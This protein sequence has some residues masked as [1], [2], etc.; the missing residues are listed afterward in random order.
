LCSNVSD[1]FTVVNIGL[2]EELLNGFE[3]YPNPAQTQVNIALP[4]SAQIRILDASGREVHNQWVEQRT[5]IDVQ[6]WARGVYMVQLIKS[7]GIQTL[8]VMLN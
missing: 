3:I 6:Q 4:G 8:P 5:A 1:A 2:D 7:D